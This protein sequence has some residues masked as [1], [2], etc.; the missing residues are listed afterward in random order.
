MHMPMPMPISAIYYDVEERI[1][2][3]MMNVGCHMQSF[4]LYKC[5]SCM[6]FGA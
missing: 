5:K 1:V 2:S 4:N 6:D 3:M